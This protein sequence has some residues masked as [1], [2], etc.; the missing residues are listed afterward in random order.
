MKT[1]MKAIMAME[2][3]IEQPAA[4][5]ATKAIAVMRNAKTEK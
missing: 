4:T 1:A 3:V 2:E 5:K